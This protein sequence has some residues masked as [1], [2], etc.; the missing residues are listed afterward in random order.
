M[1]TF[2]KLDDMAYELVTDKDIIAIARENQHPGKGEIT[3]QNIPTTDFYRW[4]TRTGTLWN[5][6]GEL[7]YIA[8]QPN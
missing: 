2:T 4:Y 1:L 7:M 3:L 8:N 5:P 6:V